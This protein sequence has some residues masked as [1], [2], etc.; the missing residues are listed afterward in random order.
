MRLR[1]FRA[2]RQE[3]GLD[4]ALLHRSNVV[5]DARAVTVARRDQ[6]P[7]VSAGG[8]PALL[9]ARPKV[10]QRDHQCHRLER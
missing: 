4:G 7:E 2:E 1:R 6:R 8:V 9:H 10:G 3:L 5:P